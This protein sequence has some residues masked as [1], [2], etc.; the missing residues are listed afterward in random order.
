MNKKIAEKIEFFMIGL[1]GRFE[2]NK[3]FFDK[4][5]V[6]L[7]SGVKCF[8]IEAT[9]TDGKLQFTYIGNKYELDFTGFINF[10]KETVLSYD[11]MVL[12]YFERGKTVYINAD[13]KNV[14]TSMQQTTYVS[15]EEAH[16]AM[17]VMSKRA[18][19]VKPERAPKLLKTIGILGGNGKVK[20][21]KIRKYNQIDHFVEIIHP[22]LEE[23]ANKNDEIRIIDCACG[24]SYLSFVLN[25][26]IREVLGKKCYILGLDY[27]E[28]VIEESKRMASELGYKNMQFVCTDI[29]AYTPDSNYQLL[30]SLHACDTA[31]DKALRFAMQHNIQ[32]IVCVPCCHKEL[33][34][35]QYTLPGFDSITKHGILRARIAD[36]LTDGM[37]LLYL[38]AMGYETS[39]VDYISPLD[40]PKNLM[41]RAI[42]KGN[43][44]QN[45]MQEFESICKILGCDLSIAHD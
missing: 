14:T 8:G 4:I 37:R 11:E 36:S 44:N 38:E 30:L 12:A 43:Y 28:N 2:E 19:Y 21:D 23:L 20:N 41:I 16:T 31:T 27:N 39:I 33:N 3:D 9:E 7:K 15:H 32:S 5:T 35:S 25:Y 13:N 42:K 24:K 45:K 26:Y 10:V 18:Y 17:D 40:T 22:L 34:K 1:A 6:S 29:R